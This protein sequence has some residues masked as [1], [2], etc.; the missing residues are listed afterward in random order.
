MG[1][2]R[3][4]TGDLWPPRQGGIDLHPQ[5]PDMPFRWYVRRAYS[6]RLFHIELLGSFRKMDELVLRRLESCAMPTRP[7]FADLLHGPQP[8]AV[9]LCASSICQ[10]VDVVNESR[11]CDLLRRRLACVQQ[12]SVK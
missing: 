9:F 12:A 10:Q 8:F 11:R 3:Y 1:R 5:D 6:D 7:L 2:F 4:N